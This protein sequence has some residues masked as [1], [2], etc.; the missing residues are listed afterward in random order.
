M[1]NTKSKQKKHRKYYEKGIHQTC[2]NILKKTDSEEENVDFV[3]RIPSR[4]STLKIDVND[5]NQTIEVS[6]DVENSLSS[7]DVEN[8]SSSTNIENSPSPEDSEIMVDNCFCE[9]LKIQN[10]NFVE[11]PKLEEKLK[12]VDGSDMFGKIRK[13][14]LCHLGN[15]ENEKILPILKIVQI[16]LLRNYPELI[17]LN[18][19]SKLAI[20]VPEWYLTK[21]QALKYVDTSRGS[22]LRSV[23]EESAKKWPIRKKYFCDN[24]KFFIGARRAYSGDL[25]EK[26]VYEVLRKRFVNSDKIVAIFNGLNI[27]KLNL[28]NTFKLSEKDFIIINATHK[29]IMV[30]E[31][32]K[33]SWTWKFFVKKYKTNN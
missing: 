5:Q 30:I 23:S 22:F 31:V 20:F 33:I 6:I 18:V 32:K 3:Q 24:E 13:E 4:N 28:A 15:G 11:G 12:P 9:T 17:G 21:P 10:F 1:G 27:L 16:L 25:P 19:K 29:Y 26:H 14:L 7:K 8:S 2:A